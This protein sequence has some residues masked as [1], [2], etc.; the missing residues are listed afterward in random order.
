M[1]YCSDCG[2][3]IPTDENKCLACGRLWSDPDM[4]KAADAGSSA[5]TGTGMDAAQAR[6]AEMRAS[7]ERYKKEKEAGSA[8]K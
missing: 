6:R 7:F 5:D 4:S 8:G 3:Y 1:R 2:C